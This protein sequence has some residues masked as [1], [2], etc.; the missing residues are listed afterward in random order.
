MPIAHFTR[1]YRLS[2]SH[3]LHAPSLNDQQNRDTYGK[4]NNPYGHGH[5]YFV[6]VTVAGPIDPETGFVVDMPKLDALAKRELIDRFDA[7][8]MN[9]DPVFNGDFVPSTENLGI[10]VERVFRRAVPLL[11]PTCQLRLHRIRIE[12]TKNNSFDLLAPG[13]IDALIPHEQHALQ[14]IA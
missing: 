9:A 6:E 7:Q 14:P 4:C 13:Q 10:E 2:A 1:R 12:E 8:H 3:R 5:N 11:D